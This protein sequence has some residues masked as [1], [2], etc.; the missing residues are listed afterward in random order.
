M[1]AAVTATGDLAGTSGPDA[2]PAG[3]LAATARA[4]TGR[5]RAWSEGRGRSRTGPGPVP[6]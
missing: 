4:L 6:E 2:L 1:A 5:P 3:V